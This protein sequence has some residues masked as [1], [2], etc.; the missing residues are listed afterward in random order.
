[1]FNIIGLQTNIEKQINFIGIIL[2]SIDILPNAST[3]VLN[4]ILIVYKSTLKSIVNEN[5]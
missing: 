4:S 5:K 1:M 2:L 3:I